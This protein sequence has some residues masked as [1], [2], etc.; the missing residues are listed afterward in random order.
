MVIQ[1]LNK[2]M[3]PTLNIATVTKERNIYFL[4][5]DSNVANGIEKCE[6][7]LMQNHKHKSTG[8]F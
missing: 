8:I 1:T 4:I 2:R 6:P 3:L 5:L 7:S